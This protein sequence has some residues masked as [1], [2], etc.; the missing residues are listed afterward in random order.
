MNRIFIGLV[1]SVP[2]WACLITPA[3]SASS[4]SKSQDCYIEWE[5]PTENRDGSLYDNPLGV[6]IY[7]DLHPEVSRVKYLFARGVAYP[8]ERVNLAQRLDIG[9]YWCAVYA[10]NQRWKFSRRSNVIDFDVTDP[11]ACID[12]TKGRHW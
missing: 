7:C 3:L 11:A 9:L 8:R 6:A 10:V 1:L 2:V 12:P 5:N 4:S